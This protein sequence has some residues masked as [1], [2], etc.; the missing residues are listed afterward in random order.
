MES[1]LTQSERGRGGWWCRAG[2][3]GMLLAGIAGV[4]AE[5][6]HPPLG[7]YVH[8]R[9]EHFAESRSYADGDRLVVTPYFYWYDAGSGAHLTNADGSDALTDHPPTLEGFSYKLPQWHRQELL[10]MVAAGIDV[11]LPVYWGEPSQRIPGAPVSAQPWSYS[12]IPPLVQAR[13]GLL[14]EGIEPPLIGLFYD[15]STLEYNA[16]G[17][18]IDLTTPRGQQWFYESV[19]DFFSLVP[20][21]HWA[22]IDGRPI[23]FLYSAAFAVA[24]DQRCIDFLQESFAGDF[25]GREL[26]IVREISWQVTTANVYAWGGA[27]GLKNPG[28]ASL[29]PGYDHSAVPGREPLVVDRQE[30][31]FFELNWIRFLRRPTPMVMIETWNE[32]HEG[33][34]IA[35]S[36]EYGREYIELNRKYADLFRA[37]VR[38]P[39][40]RGPY[41]D[42]KEV[43]VELSTMNGERGLA[44]VESADGVTA[45]LEVA[46]LE[47]RRVVPT[48]HGGRYVYFR[49]DDS[50]KWAESMWV[51]V[52]VEYYDAAAGGFRIEYDGS[53]PHAPFNGAYTSA[54]V[55]V[56]LHGSR[57]WKTDRVRLLGAR[58][59]NGQNSGA[60][61]RLVIETPEFYVRRVVVMRFG[62]P[63]ESGTVVPGFQQDFGEPWSE[64]WHVS[65]N[66]GDL[67]T[68]QDGLVALATGGARDLVLALPAPTVTDPV[69]EVLMRLRVSGMLAVGASAGGLSF[70]GAESDRTGLSVELAILPDGRTGLILADGAGDGVGRSGPV[71]WQGNRWYWLRARHAPNAISGYPDLLARLWPADGESVEPQA[72]TVYWDYHPGREL[73][74]GPAGMRA[75]SEGAQTRLECDY[76]LVKADGLDLIT[77]RMPGLKPDRPELKRAAASDPAGFGFELWGRPS[78]VYVVESSSDL[79]T[80]SG[81]VA[82]TDQGGRCQWTEMGA[83]E[84]GMGFYRARVSE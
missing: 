46:G 69:C 71:H 73:R 30:G 31:G 47:C 74:P 25:G 82:V 64:M 60:D 26:H 57:E 1:E 53:E 3:A 67:P 40:P 32:Y 24:H 81:A 59:L 39:Y 21:K 13:E 56:T 54:P 11:V 7:P 50:F 42:F 80:W 41:S 15:T 33:T 52:E 37:G 72:W 9:P 19:R 28:V 43:S 2:S 5:Q 36:L 79:L 20:P 29:G 18:R 63:A 75:P 17:T 8:L 65:G 77:V 10:D 48:E 83:G 45:A 70:A 23:V 6:I 66:H 76:F 38:P 58:F 12:G 22:M 51:D 55:Q 49:I 44:Q 4:I 16:E 34:Q 78:A 35:A 27:L 14:A 61:F 62:V 68:P 84:E